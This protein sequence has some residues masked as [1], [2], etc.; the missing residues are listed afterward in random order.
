MKKLM[1]AFLLGIFLV[2]TVVAGTVEVDVIGKQNTELIV[3][4][5]CEDQGFACT[6]RFNCSITIKNPTPQ[7]IV[8]NQTMTP[9]QTSFQFTMPSNLTFALGIYE[10]TVYC[11][12]STNSGTSTSHFEITRSGGKLD[13][14]SSV[15]YVL[16]LVGSIGV[17]L[18]SIF[19]AFIIPWR[20]PK[21][22]DGYISSINY[23]KHFKVSLIFFCYLLLLWISNIMLNITNNFLFLSV[24]FNFFRVIYFILLALFI[25]I[26]GLT[27]LII[28]LNLVND[29][30]IKTFL[31]RGIKLT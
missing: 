21:G 25:P 10:K 20:H 11:S 1:L 12:N 29:K 27:V 24:A 17:L 28:I 15:I 3:F 16:V 19:G 22:T 31:D 7:I 23:L 13:T 5:E 14:P 9:N 4:E 6:T 26:I 2:G 30:R 18:L 8:L